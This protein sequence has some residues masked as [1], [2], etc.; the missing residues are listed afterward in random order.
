MGRKVLDNDKTL[1]PAP[2]DNA[3][4]ISQAERA[5]EIEAIARI[6]GIPPIDTTFHTYC[7]R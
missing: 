1:E 7:I 2:F 6:D 5:A 4:Q 3:T